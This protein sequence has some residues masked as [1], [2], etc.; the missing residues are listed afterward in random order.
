[1]SSWALGSHLEQREE[2]S[3]H[4]WCGIEGGACSRCQAIWWRPSGDSGAG[5]MVAWS[6]D[7]HVGD[8]VQAKNGLVQAQMFRTWDSAI[9]WH[10]IVCSLCTLHLCLLLA[11]NRSPPSSTPTTTPTLTTPLDPS[12]LPALSFSLAISSSPPPRAAPHLQPRIVHGR[13]PGSL[14]TIR[15]PSQTNTRHT[16]NQ[17]ACLG[18]LEQTCTPENQCAALSSPLPERHQPPLAFAPRARHH[19]VPSRVS[20]SSDPRIHQH[21][22]RQQESLQAA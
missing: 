4:G 11:R 18:T 9:V 22:R 14:A 21:T 12:A 2:R 15:G 6:D 16:P 19:F 3:S 1:M 8:V 17:T 5:R 10:N 7:G 13:R 20:R